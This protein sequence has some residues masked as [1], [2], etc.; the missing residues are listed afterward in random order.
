MLGKHV[1]VRGVGWIAAA[2]LLIAGC[3]PSEEV[4]QQL[5][6]L[7]VVTAQKDSM[8]QVVAEY[9]QVMSDISAELAAVEL[10]GR[11]LLVAIESPVAASRDSILGKI[12]MLDDRLQQSEQRLSQSR[13]RVS[14]LTQLSDR[15]RNTLESTIANYESVLASHRESIA[16]LNEQV[17]SLQ[18]QTE[19]L[20][21][22]VSELESELTT[23][24]TVYYTIATKDE[25]LERGIIEK[26]GGS[27]FLFIFGKRGE[28]LVPA[29][30]LDPS[31]FTAIDSREV[32]EIPVPNPD[33]AYTIV[34]HH[35]V[36][37]LENMPDEDGNIRGT[38]RIASP[39]EFWNASP[40]LII[41]EGE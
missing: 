11:E 26:K 41:V 12:R 20:A 29:T 25:L 10:E 6:E 23:A 3:G 32:S 30:D 5:A 18:T 36:D 9:A 27:R 16:S 34:S 1:K 14:G 15:L 21:A 17:A 31:N 7:Q 13:R 4:Q 39:S 38:I 28:T 24:N 8:I 19:T 22:E 40:F 35:N 2:A 33:A 37:L